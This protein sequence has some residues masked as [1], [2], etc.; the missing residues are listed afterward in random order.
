MTDKLTPFIRELCKTERFGGRCTR[1]DHYTWE[2]TDV[3]TWTEDQASCLQSRFPSIQI[4][5]VS[6]RKSLSGFSLQLVHQ[7]ASQAWLSLLVTTA[8]V[9]ANAALATAVSA[10]LGPR[11]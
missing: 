2:V 11:A 10:H 1:I 3:S 4:K 6:D 5:I 7:V 8:M 9:A